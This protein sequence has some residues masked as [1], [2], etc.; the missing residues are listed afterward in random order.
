MQKK[1]RY[2]KTATHQLTMRNERQLITFVY[3]KL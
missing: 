3:H 2:L 1:T